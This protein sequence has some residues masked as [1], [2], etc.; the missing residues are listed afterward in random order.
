M[1]A[2]NPS[3]SNELRQA[4]ALVRYI[5]AG[6]AAELT[7]ELP[8]HVVTPDGRLTMRVEVDRE[9]FVAQVPIR[10]TSC[11]TARRR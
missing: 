9:A 10:S 1:T 5:E 8:L 3:Q 7:F 6:G 2:M 11:V 4:K